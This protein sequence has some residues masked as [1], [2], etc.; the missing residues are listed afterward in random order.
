[1]TFEDDKKGKVLSTGIIKVNDHFTLNDVSLVD[2]LRYNLLSVSKLVD[3]D[4]EII[5]RKSSLQVLGSSSRL[6]CGIS[7]IGKVFQAEFSFAQSSLKCLILQSLFEIWKWHRRLGHLSFDLLCRLRVLGLLRRLPLLKFESN[8]V[9]AS[10]CHGKMIVTSHSPVNTVMTEQHSYSIWTLSVP[11]GFA[12]WEASH[13]FLSS[14]M[15][16]LVTLGFSS[17]KV[18]MKCLSTFGAWL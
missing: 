4:F 18:M 17:W 6:V 2:K 3:A 14:L 7:H 1:V 5:F 8:L 16:I 13:I 11:L 12:P 9:C 10:C 15:I